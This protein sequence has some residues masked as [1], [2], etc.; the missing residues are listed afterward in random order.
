MFEEVG[1]THDRSAQHF[2]GDAALA[3]GRAAAQAA[4]VVGPVSAAPSA[5][6]P[7]PHGHERR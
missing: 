4:G 6:V 3:A 2:F 7:R 5:L 1:I